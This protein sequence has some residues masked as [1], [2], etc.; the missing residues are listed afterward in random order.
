M[1]LTLC[2]G[3]EVHLATEASEPGHGTCPHLEHVDSPRLEA[4]DD[5]RVSLT[6]H[7]G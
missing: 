1:L 3:L 5:G 7:D 4:T 2:H 6:P